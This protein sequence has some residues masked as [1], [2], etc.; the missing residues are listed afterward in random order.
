M[1]SSIPS[2]SRA[3]DPF[4]SYN[5]DTVNT[6]TRMLTYGENGLATAVSCDVIDSTSNTEVTLKPGFVYKDDMWIYISANH[7][8]DFTDSQHYDDFDAGFDEAGYYYIVLDY[9]FVKSRPAPQSRIKI[10]R[11]SERLTSFPNSNLTFLKVADVALVGASNEIVDLLDYDPDD[12]SVQRISIQQYAST[13]IFLPTFDRLQH[14]GKI[15][16]VKSADQYYYGGE[17]G[18][19]FAGNA[20]TVNETITAPGGWTLDGGVYRG[21]VDITALSTMNAIVSVRRDSDDMIITPTNIEFT[22]ATNVRIW[23]PVNTV[24]VHVTIVA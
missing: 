11:P 2:Q 5:S 22:S 23:M 12:T 18:W 20:V 1:A 21:D 9:E 4:A 6:L 3:V 10:I 15:L 24:T 16:Y 7:I 13:E 17:T 19:T 14:Q 8:V